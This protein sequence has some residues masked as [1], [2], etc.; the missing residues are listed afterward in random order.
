MDAIHRTQEICIDE[1]PDRLG[2]IS[3]GFR[4][5]TADAGVGDH[6]VDMAEFATHFVCCGL[7]NRS[8][9]HVTRKNS[10][11]TAFL[12]ARFCQLLKLIFSA[13]QETENCPSLS[14]RK[15]QSFADAAR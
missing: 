4:I 9:S 15:C 8:L 7:N 1:L 12:T 5:V 2:V 10:C 11:L 6:Y 13:C 3:S 14:H